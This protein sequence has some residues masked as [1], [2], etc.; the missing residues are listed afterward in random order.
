MPLSNTIT[1]PEKIVIGSKTGA[2]TLLDIEKIRQLIQ[3]MVSNDLVEISLR[4]GD[5]EVSLRRP[6]ANTGVEQISVATTQIP[7]ALVPAEE[8]GQ[9]GKQDKDEDADLVEI[10]SPMVG[11]FYSASDPDTPAFAKVG[12]HVHADTVICIV[13]AMKVFNEIKA[14][15]S[16]TIE[17]ILV[18]NEQALEY[19]QPMFLV[20]PQ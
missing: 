2:N 17:R 12:M 4:D 16:G 11:T 15:V 6:T 18:K 3:M 20:R 19:G 13:E 14:E 5:V 1:E 9:G 10:S 7:T 8:D